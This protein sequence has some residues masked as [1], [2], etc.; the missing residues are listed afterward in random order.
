MNRCN[1]DVSLN[2]CIVLLELVELE[3]SFELLFANDCIYIRQIVELAI[4]PS[5]EFN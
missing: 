5:N 3:K 2:S 4:D 1:D